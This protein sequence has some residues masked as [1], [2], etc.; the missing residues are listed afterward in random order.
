MIEDPKC[1]VCENTLKYSDNYEAFYCENCNE[2]SEGLC[3][4]E[5][6]FYCT[7]R[8]SKPIELL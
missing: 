7:N 8:P 5:K 2:W 1:H 6:C 4:D 3:R